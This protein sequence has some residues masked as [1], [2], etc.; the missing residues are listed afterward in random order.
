MVRIDGQMNAELE[1][2]LGSTEIMADQAR[3]RSLGYWLLSDLFLEPPQAAGLKALSESLRVM[4]TAGA[5]GADIALLQAMVG[6]AMRDPDETAVAFTRDLCLGDKTR[7]DVLPF[8]SHVREGK[9]PGDATEL[10]IAMMAEAGYEE[11]APQAASPDHLGAELRFMALLCHAEHEAWLGSADRDAIASLRLQKRFLQ[12]HLAQWGPE[13]C[14]ALAGRT[15]NGYVRAIAQ[16]T[17]A[18]VRDDVAVLEEICRAIDIESKA[19][20]PAF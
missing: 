10:V 15:N 9:L 8:E 14:T 1:T 12:S 7:D 17:A 4:V 5:A 2:R 13:Y 6:V 3:Q 18:R 11:V 20:E 19:T 16:L